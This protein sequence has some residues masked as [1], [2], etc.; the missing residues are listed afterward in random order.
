MFL[1]SG[2]GRNFIA[3]YYFLSTYKQYGVPDMKKHHRCDSN[4]YHP[5]NL[6][7][8]VGTEDTLTN[9]EIPQQKQT[10]PQTKS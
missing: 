7:Q 4:F 9:K 6:E 2:E 5:T 3:Q 1:F 8:S 10:T